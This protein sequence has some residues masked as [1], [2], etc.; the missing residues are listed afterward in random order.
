MYKY[1]TGIIIYLVIISTLISVVVLDAKGEEQDYIALSNSITGSQVEFSNIDEYIDAK[2]LA[3]S[4]WNV[5]D[6]TLIYEGISP[7]WADI[8]LKGLQPDNDGY[9]TVKYEFN[10]PNNV[11]IRFIIQKAGLLD[12][13]SYYLVY[14]GVSLTIPEPKADIPILDLLFSDT[15]YKMNADLSG[16]NQSITTRYNPDSQHIEIYHN[17]DYLGDAYGKLDTTTASHYGGIGVNGNYLEVTKI[18]TDINITE[19][20]SFTDLFGMISNVIF[21]TI[22][23][24][25][26]PFVYNLILIKLPI[27]LLA[28][29][30]IFWVRGTS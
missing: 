21:Y 2:L 23:E 27:A 19:E 14:D 20:P 3:G 5:V 6:N 30:I 4:Y 18:T 26:F 24:K 1:F 17:D 9:Y 10:N 16:N 7:N 12:S 13:A 11:Y 29:G 22:D 8:N 28:I 15:L 25:Y